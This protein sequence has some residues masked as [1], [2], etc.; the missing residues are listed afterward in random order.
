MQLIGSIRK[1]MVKLFESSHGSQEPWETDELEFER[2]FGC[3]YEEFLLVLGHLSKDQYQLFERTVAVNPE[4][5]VL[6][7][8]AMDV[9]HEE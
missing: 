7:I 4:A 3:P 2:H 5:A 6:W 8:L 1:A 9:V